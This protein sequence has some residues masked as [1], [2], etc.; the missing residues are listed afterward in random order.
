MEL[1]SYFEKFLREIRPTDNQKNECKDGHT[2]LRNRLSG[3]EDLKPILV[4]TFLQGSYR[5]ATAI[6]PKGDTRSDVDTIVV[7]KLNQNKYPD[8]NKAMDLFVPFLEKYYKGKYERQ[9]RSFGIELSYIDLDLVITSAPSES[10]EDLLKS[11]AVNTYETPEDAPEWR[12]VKSWIP[13]FERQSTNLVSVK[14]AIR[15]ESEWKVQPLWIP[16]RETKSWKRTHPLEQIKWTFGKNARCNY[17][18]VNIVK[19]I[20]WWQ[21]INYNED[22]LS[23]YPLEHLIGICCPDRIQSIA[24]GVTLTLEQI[25]KDYQSYTSSKLTPFLADHGVPEHNVLVRITGDEFAQF[26][27]HVASAAKIARA[28]LDA[29]SVVVSNEKWRELFGDKFPPSGDDQNDK[30]RDPKGPFTIKSQ[31]GDLTP[32]RYGNCY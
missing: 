8:P 11:A 30:E 25:V 24:V 26:Y 10:E 9:G 29:G 32:R 15:K 21:R 12:L 16:D 31:T 20:K 17:H 23:G 19:A 13:L 1:K 5:R 22:C 3:Y 27:N 18:Y 7:T 2:T 4:T 6:R 14:E 28:A